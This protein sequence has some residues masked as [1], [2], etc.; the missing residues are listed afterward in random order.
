MYIKDNKKQLYQWDL[1]QK[2]VV[3]NELVKEVH[4][5]NPTTGALVVIVEDGMAN[6]PNILLQE[7]FDIKA[8][9][10][11]GECV[12]E[13][14]TINVIARAK[15]EDYVYT[16]TE[17]K[18]WE[19]YGK[20]IEELEERIEDLEKPPYRPT[21]DS[22]FA[23]N[24]WE[25]IAWV[26]KHDNPANYWKVGDYKEVTIGGKTYPIQIIGF[27]HD[28]VTNNFSYGKEKAGLTLMIGC[29]RGVYGDNRVGVYDRNISTLSLSTSDNHIHSPNKIAADG[30]I[31]AEG[32]NWANGGFRNYLN[33]HFNS[34]LPYEVR[35]HIVGVDKVYSNFFSAKNYYREMGTMSERF[36]LLSEYEM[37]GEQLVTKAPEG[38][39]Y[40]IFKIGKSK[41]II[42]PEILAKINSG[43]TGIAYSRLWLRSVA[44]KYTDP[45]I[46]SNDFYNMTEGYTDNPNYN[47]SG[48]STYT[49]SLLMSYN[50]TSKVFNYLTGPA[51]GTSVPAYIAPCF[52][53]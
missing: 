25:T 24:D 52:C 47:E 14:L 2:I 53:M 13:T 7:A 16:E 15:P 26:A 21:I 46:P 48:V 12:R 41:L 32:T 37:Y 8:F 50:G 51:S 35:K 38:E 42:T 39:Q 43:A 1:N 22:H 3:E 36:F 9:G 5:S 27:N 34:A 28:K 40:E 6:I 17:L 33:Y 18:T 45:Y 29:T 49:N 23:N 19:E 4:F 30:S 10:Y 44:S 20:Q 31:T 11:C